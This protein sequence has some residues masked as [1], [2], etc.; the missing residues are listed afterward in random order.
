[1]QI[2]MAALLASAGLLGGVVT[3]LV[4]GASLITFPALLAA[5]LPPIRERSI[6]SG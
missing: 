2:E 3:A 6:I 5:G 4:G 1:M